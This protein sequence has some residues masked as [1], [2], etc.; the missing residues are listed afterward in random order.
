MLTYQVPAHHILKHFGGSCPGLK[1]ERHKNPELTIFPVS[2][3]V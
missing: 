2:E 1:V 3:A